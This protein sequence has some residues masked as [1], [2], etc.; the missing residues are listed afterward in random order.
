M[1]IR[2]WAGVP[3]PWERV[4]SHRVPKRSF[5]PTAKTL[6]TFSVLTNRRSL[7][8]DTTEAAY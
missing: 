8:T 6:P 1:S 3:V 7:A 2:E 5:F 4:G